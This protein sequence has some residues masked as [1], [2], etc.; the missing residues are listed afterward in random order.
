MAEDELQPIIQSMEELMDDNT[1]PKNVKSKVGEVIR[2]LKDNSDTSI[3]INKAL[4]Y[5]EDRIPRARGEAQKVIRAAEAYKQERVL[6]SQGEAT[7]FVAILLEYKK[8]R[9]VTRERLHLETMERILAGVSKKVFID[10]DVAK[11]ALPFLPLT[12]AGAIQGAAP[13]GGK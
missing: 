11:N 8:A 3:K 1:V 2:N 6:R 13:E 9:N 4:G 12:G 7:R 10:K 5:R